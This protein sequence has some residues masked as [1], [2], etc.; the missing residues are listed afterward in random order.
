MEK[1]ARNLK[2]LFMNVAE[3]PEKGCHA[4]FQK[5]LFKNVLFDIISKTAAN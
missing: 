2:A 1:G 5:A 3:T 4:T